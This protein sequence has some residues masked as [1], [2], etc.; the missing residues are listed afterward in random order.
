VLLVA[1]VVAVVA[2][3]SCSHGRVTAQH[4]TAQHSTVLYCTGKYSSWLGRTQLASREHS[5][6]T[7]GADYR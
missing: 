6:S 2:G 7:D 1:A 3:S 4:S 5:N